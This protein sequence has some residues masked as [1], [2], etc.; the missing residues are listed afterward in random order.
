V[1]QRIAIVGASVRAA[2]ASAARAGFQVL[3]ADLFADADLCRI[4]AATRIR[5]YPAELHDWLNQ[6]SPPP[7]AWMYTGA[8]ENH[9]D[10]VDRMAAVAPLWG[11][12]G[13]VLRQ[14][15]SPQGLADVMR[16]ANFRFPEVRFSPAGLPDDGSW[17]EKTGRGAGGSGIRAFT[18]ASPRTDGVFYQRRVA[19]APHS[20][21]FVAAK[22]EVTFLGIVRQ[23]IGESWLNAG[24]FQ[25]CG[26]IGPSSVSKP[27]QAEIERIGQMLAQEFRLV[28]LFGV[29]LVIDGDQ[30]WTIE[31]NPRY[32][33]SIEIIERATGFHAVSSH[34]AA[35]DNGVLPNPFPL[36]TDV[37]LGKA[38]L[39]AKQA[40][41][42][43]STFAD[44]AL[45]QATEQPWPA[46]ADVPKAGTTIER[47]HPV[48]TIFAESTSGE[49][50]L[51]ILRSRVAKIERKLYAY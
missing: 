7:S 10:L 30:V 37:T 34:A 4:A 28:G 6:F 36:R 21:A 18:G 35:C 20:A 19:G 38:I 22:G 27:I 50:A 24:E 32:T 51:Q 42:V 25:Y 33:A 26:A 2:A 45:T 43:C 39:F 23:L 9:P 5:Q 8:L 31:A 1:T 48:L 46:L 15:R 29:D 44:W 40:V 49:K 41:T 14:V 17:L 3:A 47:G 12:D 11:N 13:E 16:S